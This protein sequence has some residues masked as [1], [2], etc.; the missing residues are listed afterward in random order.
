[1]VAALLGAVIL[2]VAY[3]LW[4]GAAILLQAFAGVLFAVF[5]AALSD[6]VRRGTRLPY[7]WSLAVV[8]AGLL[9]L[10]GGLGYLLWNRLSHQVGEFVQ[11]LPCSFEQIKGG[12]L[13]Y[14]W[15]QYL[16]ENAPAAA[17]GLAEAGPFT[18]LT[19]FASGV[20]GFLEAAAVI[21]IV[22]RFGAAEPE[23]YQAGLLHL[24]PP[25]QRRRVGEAVGAIA[26]NLRHWLVGQVLLMAIS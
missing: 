6:G 25:E 8:V 26:L 7:R 10:A 22:G 20:A 15:G 17:S 24:V 14:P 5:L 3:F 19:G 13:Q 11:T 16:V 1:V 12:P 18:H 4:R 9:L 21:V 2:A 23:L